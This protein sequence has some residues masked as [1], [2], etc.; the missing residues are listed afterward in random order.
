MDELIEYPDIQDK[1]FYNIINSKK[2]FSDNKLTLSDISLDSCNKQSFKIFEH[3]LFIR[4]F[5][6]EN[7]PYKN[8]LLFHATGMGKTCS[9]ILIAEANRNSIPKIFVFL[10]KS[11]KQNYINEIYDE[12][13]DNNQCTMD[14]Y[15]NLDKNERNKVIKYNYQIKQLGK[16]TNEICLLRKTTIGQNKIKNMFSNSLIIID[17]VHNIREYNNDEQTDCRRYDAIESILKYSENIKLVLMSA[18]PIFDTPEEIISITNLFLINQKKNKINVNDIFDKNLNL[19]SNGTEILKTNL[20]GII[21]YVRG[22]NP[23]TFPSWSFNESKI[24]KYKFK[25]FKLTQIEM[26]NYQQENYIKNYSEFN[27][28]INIL[29]Q[30]SNI[31]YGTKD[32][33]NELK[34]EKLKDPENSISMK[35][36]N[37]YENIINSTGTNFVYS[38]FINQGVMLI[39]RMLIINGFK[40][41]NLKNKIDLEG[42]GI[43]IIDGNTDIIKRK[44]IIDIF[45]SI[46][47][48]DGK[49]IKVLIGSSVLKE[50]ITLKNTRNVHIMEPWHNMSR[51][52]QIWG[53]AIRSC[54]HSE[55]QKKDRNVK[56]FLY[57]SIFNKNLDIE[58]YD[59]QAY[60]RSENKEIKIQKIINI[61]RSIAI[62]CYTH[63]DYNQNKR[64]NIEC[65]DSKKIIKEDTS[66][67]NLNLNFF[68]K[69]NII[70]MINKIKFFIKR[71]YFYKLPP[72]LSSFMKLVLKELIPSKNTDL[73]HFK[74]TICINEI[75]GYIIYKGNYLVFQPLS[76]NN[77]L[78]QFYDR[79]N[80][81]KTFY[82]IP[83]DLKDTVFKENDKKDK[84]ELKIKKVNEELKVIH[85]DSIRG[86]Y[87]GILMSDNSL[88]L[89][90]KT[91]IRSSGRFCTSF[92][93]NE[94]LDVIKNIGIK[95]DLV[96]EHLIDLP[97]IKNKQGL[98]SIITNYFY[99]KIPVNLS[100]STK[101]RK[102][103]EP[104]I[105][106]ELLSTKIDY[107][108]ISLIL[109]MDKHFIRIT[110]TRLP[111][112]TG[113]LCTNKN[114]ISLEEIMKLL[115]I[116]KIPKKNEE[117]CNSIKKFMETKYKNNK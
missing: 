43:V 113:T 112:R 27:T 12:T 93:G 110:D 83:F 42:K 73:K 10:E 1:N 14:I 82:D 103:M 21:S 23:I 8:L 75:N 105:E 111:I 28:N 104:G 11:V 97:R 24:Q 87:I 98:C 5:F 4:N 30:I 44:M 101:K 96:K 38:E 13:R 61:L 78:I 63:K 117:K 74:H 116:K 33:K 51:L 92:N 95:N 52:Y 65:I 58:P 72:K 48:K 59:I 39:K 20:R 67:F 89:K 40:L 66:T 99:E 26:S 115:E 7:T 81:K 45:N 88:K 80:S 102:I 19:T 50:G 15:S 60:K 53:R 64:D 9:S 49:Y 107:F 57:A 85:E 18:T 62:D 3:Q 35:F 16:L 68:E 54:S 90:L 76:N 34:I 56:I 25:L 109:R 47:N 31:Y 70:T 106:I 55:L 79:K 114:N 17:E 71:D 36:Y 100:I 84:K 46:E 6:N 22:D 108:I 32:L 69:P 29:R 37:L 41:F 91:D 94:M 86:D 77:E 2:E